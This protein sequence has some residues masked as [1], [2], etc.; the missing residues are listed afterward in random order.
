MERIYYNLVSIK[1]NLTHLNTMKENLKIAK[2]FINW[3]NPIS[4]CSN[5]LSPYELSLLEI[6]QYR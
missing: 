4:N 6:A 2:C 5:Y 1:K 3:G